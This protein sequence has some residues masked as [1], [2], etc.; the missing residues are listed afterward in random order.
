[1]F[2]VAPL[3]LVA[4]LAWIEQGLPRPI[5][6]V[7]INL[8]FW[9]FGSIWRRSGGIFIRRGDAGPVYKFALREWLGTLVE[10]RRQLRWFIE[11][12]RSRTG[13]LGPSKLGLLVWPSTPSSARTSASSSSG[14]TSRAGE[15]TPCSAWVCRSAATVTTS[16]AASAR[17]SPS[18]GPAGRSI[19]T[20]WD[21]VFGVSPTV[22]V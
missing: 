1:M 6:F 19:P 15:S 22:W 8:A 16:A 18:E 10:H 11:G 13:K 4:L 3:L 14:V 20:S 2:Y 12:S 9:P 7:G 17:T 5:E 21:P